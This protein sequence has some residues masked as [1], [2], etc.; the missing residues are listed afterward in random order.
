MREPARHSMDDDQKYE[1]EYVAGVDEIRRRGTGAV[2]YHPGMRSCI[3]LTKK[4]ERDALFDRLTCG[5][6]P[7]YL[8]SVTNNEEDFGDD[9]RDAYVRLRKNKLDVMLGQWTDICGTLYRD[10]TMA[11]SGIGREQALKY[12]HEYGQAYIVVLERND[13]PRFL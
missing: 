12:K 1:A 3:D 9:T 6:Q 2:T 10:V 5:E 8:I 4:N 11:V 13:P 7:V